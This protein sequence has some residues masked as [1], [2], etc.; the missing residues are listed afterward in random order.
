MPTDTPVVT[1]V[2]VG[3][4]L[5]DGTFCAAG[6]RCPSPDHCNTCSCGP[7]GSV[8][9]TLLA[10]VDAGPPIVCGGSVGS[11]PSFDRT[12]RAATDCFVGT[13]QT[14]CCGNSHAM[15]LNVSQRAAFEAAEAI[16]E[17]MY[18]RCGCPARPPVTDDGVIGTFSS[19]M[20]VDCRA[21]LCTSYLS[22]M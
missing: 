14:D 8:Q 21:G 5:S 9:C 4:R 16:C 11:F 15:G 10:C 22:M 17:P 2:G 13:H 12:C 1:D 6:T 7:N 19:V 20:S 18:P 3:C